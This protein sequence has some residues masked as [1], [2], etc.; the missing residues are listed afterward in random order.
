MISSTEPVINTMQ[1]RFSYNLPSCL[2]LIKGHFACTHQ[3]D[4]T[5]GQC[6]DI[7]N[8]ISPS[9]FDEVK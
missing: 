2:A 1:T 7:D 9:K 6:L 3:K 4:L 8:M 5:L